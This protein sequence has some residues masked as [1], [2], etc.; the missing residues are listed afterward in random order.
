MPGRRVRWAPLVA[1]ILLLVP[2]AWMAA[3][4][5]GAIWHGHPAL[6]VTL[7]V[8]AGAGVGLLVIAARPRRAR[9]SRHPRARLAGAIVGVVLTPWSPARWSG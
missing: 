4:A 2:I 6:P 5:L 9:P 1:G 3:T 8:L 7:A